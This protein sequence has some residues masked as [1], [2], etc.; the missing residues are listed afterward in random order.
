MKSWFEEIGLAGAGV[1]LIVVGI[2][3]ALTG[4]PSSWA[5]FC[6]TL[7]ISALAL[8]GVKGSKGT[9]QIIV[10]V[11]CAGFFIASIVILLTSLHL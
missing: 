10:G 5:A 3:F 4:I 2:V 7:G 8:A 9:F 11:V 1:I 6:I